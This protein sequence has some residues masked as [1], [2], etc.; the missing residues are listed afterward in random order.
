[1][2]PLGLIVCMPTR[3]SVSVETVLCINEHLRPYELLTVPRLPVVPARN[4]LAAWARESTA[5]YVLWLDDDVYF[6]RDHVETAVSILEENPVDMVASMY[7]NRC[8]Y[9]DSNAI[10]RRDFTRSIAPMGLPPG[11]LEPVSYCGFGF[12]LMRR[13]LLHRVGDKPF[14]RLPLESIAEWPLRDIPGRMAEDFS[15]CKRVHQCR[16]KIVT[17]RSLVP[18]HVDVQDGLLYYPLLPPLLANG[19]NRPLPLP[20]A[21]RSFRLRQRPHDYEMTST[22]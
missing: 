3:G 19:S 5:K 18:G 2:K 20:K 4:L 10:A 21:Y 16:G 6:T 7:S 9:G 1:M 17:E 15:F 11:Q 22:R 14:D 8:A 13:A 12:V